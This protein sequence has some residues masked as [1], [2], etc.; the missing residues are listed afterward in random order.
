MQTV[1]ATHSVSDTL[2]LFFNRQSI[3]T[4][5]YATGPNTGLNHGGNGDKSLQ[6][7]EQQTLISKFPQTS[8][9]YMPFSALTLLVW[10]QEGHPACQKLGVGLL[11]V[12][13]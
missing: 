8:A 7:M 11:V 10:Q 12:T 2:T 5:V 13:I 1:I 6:D 4:N 9:Y 3:I